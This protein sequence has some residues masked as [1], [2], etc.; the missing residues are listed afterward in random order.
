MSLWSFVPTSLV[1]AKAPS[2][3]KPSV[4]PSRN[5]CVH[6]LEAKSRVMSNTINSEHESN[7][8]ESILFIQWVN[9]K[10]K[11]SVTLLRLSLLDLSK[12]A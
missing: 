11:V 9:D 1:P 10:D 2:T 5:L 3:I 12:G 8:F 4:N 6:P 7:S